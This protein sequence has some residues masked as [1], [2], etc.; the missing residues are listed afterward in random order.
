MEI[1][2]SWLLPDSLEVRARRLPE[3]RDF[4]ADSALTVLVTPL[5]IDAYMRRIGFV[6]PARPDIETLVRVHRAHLFSITYE[7]LD[8]QLGRPVDLDIE[9]I[10]RKIVEE[11]RGGWCYEMNGLLGWALREIGFG[12]TRSNGGVM[13]AERG[14]AAIGNHV[15]L[16][17]RAEDSPD[18]W[19]ADAGFGD[20][21]AEP[22]PLS[23]GE[24]HQLGFRYALEMLPDG[25]WRF[26]NH[27]YSAATSFDFR[28]QAGDE[29]LFNEKCGWLQNSPESGFVQNLVVQ[30]VVASG[31]EVQ[32]G[33]VAM[34]VTPQG[35]ESRL[36]DTP[37]ELV[38]RLDDV[39]GLRVPGVTNLWP[40]IVARHAQLFPEPKI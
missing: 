31:Y 1:R 37:E 32:R 35:V 13:R 8:V 27:Q 34:R 3:W 14:D 6:G 21:L 7:N 29:S 11:G 20:G 2:P 30:R 25:F 23:E 17:V 10:Y 15:V 9:R 39:F 16:L 28:A 36:L 5:N 18:L 40:R 26:H 12:V 19:L 4:R 38:R 22:V 33:R 24:I